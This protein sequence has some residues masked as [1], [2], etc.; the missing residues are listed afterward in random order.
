MWI[1]L[2]G[3]GTVYTVPAGWRGRVP[4]CDPA[5]VTAGKALRKLDGG[6]LE[7]VAIGPATIACEGGE[8]LQLAVA[9]LARLE[10]TGARRIAQFAVSDYTLHAFDG[11]GRELRLGDPDAIAWTTSSNV[12]SVET[13]YHVDADRT[14]ADHARLTP[15]RAG[16]VAVTATFSGVTARLDVVIE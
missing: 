2:V 16:T 12:A 11:D 10:I 6:G 7:A 1:A 15:A 9:N 8:T 13:H 5:E 4:G 3:C 14:P